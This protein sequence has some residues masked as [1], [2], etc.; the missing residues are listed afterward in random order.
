MGRVRGNTS[1]SVYKE[2][3]QGVMSVQLWV[4]GRGIVSEFNEWEHPVMRVS[5][6]TSQQAPAHT[7]IGVIGSIANESRT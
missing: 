5:Q 3:V 4:N 2:G 1:H 7:G 6:S